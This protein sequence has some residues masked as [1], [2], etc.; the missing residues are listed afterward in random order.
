MTIVVAFW[1]SFHPIIEGPNEKVMEKFMKISRYI[2]LM[3]FFVLI[4]L[5]VWPMTKYSHKL[6]KTMIS[7]WKF[8][9]DILRHTLS[10]LSMENIGSAL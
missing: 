2:Q 5:K 7:D 1:M 3:L 8:E 10:L 4:S 9:I 6:C